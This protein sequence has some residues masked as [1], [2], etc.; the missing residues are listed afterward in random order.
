MEWLH[1]CCHVLLPCAWWCVSIFWS[2][3]FFFHI[4]GFQIFFNFSYGFLYFLPLGSW[5]F[6]HFES[7]RRPRA[8]LGCAH[9]GPSGRLHG[10]KGCVCKWTPTPQIRILVWWKYQMGVDGHRPLRWQSS[11]CPLILNTQ[12]A[13]TMWTKIDWTMASGVFSGN[14]VKK[15]IRGMIDGVEEMFWTSCDMAYS[16]LGCFENRFRQ[17][18]VYW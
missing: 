1:D 14:G 9:F 12:L 10:E 3:L 16:R 6:H 2:C 7:Q 11:H 15:W 18:F 13:P 4:Y 17:W 8:A 5:S